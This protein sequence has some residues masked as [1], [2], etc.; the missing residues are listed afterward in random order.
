MGYQHGRVIFRG[1]EPLGT[2][3]EVFDA[4][5]QAAYRGLLN[6]TQ[7]LMVFSADD[8]HICLDNLAVAARMCS[9]SVGSSHDRFKAFHTLCSVWTRRQRGI[10]D[11][12]GR[13]H[14]WWCPGHA[15]IPGN[16]EADTLAKEACKQIPDPQSQASLAHIKRQAKA[17]AFGTFAERWLSLCPQ[18]YVDLGIVPHHKPPELCLPRHLLGRLY[19]ARSHHGDFAA[20]HKRFYHEDAPLNCSCGKPK[21]PVHFYFCRRGRRATPRQLR[22]HMAK[23]GIDFLLGTA[24]GASLL[25]K[26]MEATNFFIDI[27]PMH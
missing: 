10:W 4:E 5:V 7:S 9:P 17:F 21:T 22:P 8:V 16:E 6:A 11:P 14:I 23:A 19:A 12:P 1:S 18:Q 13:V 26:W 20:Y 25:C 3:L 27:C 2:Q 15:G 24:Q